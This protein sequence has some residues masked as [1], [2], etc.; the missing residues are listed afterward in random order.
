MDLESRSPTLH[1]QWYDDSDPGVEFVVERGW[2]TELH[3]NTTNVRYNQIEVTR[4]D[5]MDSMWRRTM[6]LRLLTRTFGKHVQQLKAAEK[7]PVPASEKG[8]QGTED[9]DSPVPQVD[10]ND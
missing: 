3:I 4:I 9:A 8:T 6:E 5:L 1:K 2:L 7:T 10:R